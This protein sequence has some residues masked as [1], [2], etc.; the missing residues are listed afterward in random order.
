MSTFYMGK[1]EQIHK[2]IG[3]PW[4]P[5]IFFGIGYGESTAICI[6]LIASACKTF[7]FV[8]HMRQAA[9]ITVRVMIK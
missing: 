7:N 1:L 4:T 9:P 6:L 2:V 3:N 5:L 8:L